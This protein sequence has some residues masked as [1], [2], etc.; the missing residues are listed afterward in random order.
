[1]MKEALVSG[2]LLGMLHGAA[3]AASVV[4]NFTSG[5]VTSETTTRTE[6]VEV[7]RQVEY[8]SATSYTVTGNNINIPGSP[9]PN[10]NYSIHTQGAPFQFSETLMVPGIAKETTIE[11]TTTMDSFTTSI[12]VFTQ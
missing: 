12:S 1:M 9:G 6:V 10:T 7:I 4:P 2:F 3:Q 8:S 5:T 11:R